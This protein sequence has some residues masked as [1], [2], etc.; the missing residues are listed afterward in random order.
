M[1]EFTVY[2]HTLFD[3]RKYIGITSQ[4][5]ERRWRNGEGYKTKSSYFYRAIQKYGWDAFTHEILFEHLTEERAKQL[6][7]ELISRNKTQERA[8]G[9]NISGGGDGV[10]NPTDEVRK[11]IG[12]VSRKVNTGRKH[13]E[14]YKKL[15]SE[16]MKANN[17]NAGGK[18]L[19]AEKVNRFTE[20]AK[21]PKTDI[22]KQ[23]MSKSAKK[24]AV[25]CVETGV[26][27]ES[28]KEA[29]EK[30]GIYYTAI[31]GAVYKKSRAGGYHWE[32]I[33]EKAV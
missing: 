18:L 2:V 7:R 26:V 13:T 20:Y 5:P 9:F 3:G 8:F 32:P 10:F 11:K 21:K 6:E 30:L 16:R 4:R 31:S 1:K 23:R 17:P 25:R 15:M 28:M 12:E 33:N 27:Y 29:S 14:E 19:T 22:Q 24:R